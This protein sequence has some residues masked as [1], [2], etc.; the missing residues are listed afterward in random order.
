MTYLNHSVNISIC[1]AL[2]S[3]DGNAEVNEIQL[4]IQVWIFAE[5]EIFEH[6]ESNYL[7]LHSVFCALCAVKSALCAEH[8]AD[9]R[10]DGE[11]NPFIVH[12][13]PNGNPIK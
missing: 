9:W 4:A 12:R 2:P 1:F 5:V 13:I 8:Y 10:Y 7:L 11:I 6:S 3:A